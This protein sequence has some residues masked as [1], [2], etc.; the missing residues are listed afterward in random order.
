MAII[1]TL[2]THFMS[3]FRC[4]TANVRADI[5]DYGGGYTSCSHDLV[6]ALVRIPAFNLTKLTMSEDVKSNPGPTTVSGSSKCTSVQGLLLVIA[7]KCNAAVV[8]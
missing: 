5:L 3:S 6:T 4:F 2:P 8:K 1:A 7:V